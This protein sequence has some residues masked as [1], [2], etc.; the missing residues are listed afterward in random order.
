MGFVKLDV[1][2]HTIASG[3]ATTATITDMAKSAAANNLTLL[4]ISDHGPATFGGGKRLISAVFLM[5]KK[6]ALESRCSTAQK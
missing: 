5:H 2:T 3:H 1:H 4:G 6:S